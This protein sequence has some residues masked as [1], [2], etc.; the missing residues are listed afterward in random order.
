MNEKLEAFL[1]LVK[2]LMDDK[3]SAQVRLNFHQG[4]LSEKI[5][6]KE[7]LILE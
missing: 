2:R 1:K 5:E 4:D 3:K 7:S 6:V